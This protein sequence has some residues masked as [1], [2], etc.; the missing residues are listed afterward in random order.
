M[1]CDANFFAVSD[2]ISGVVSVSAC[3][4]DDDDITG[5]GGDVIEP[6]LNVHSGDDVD[7]MHGDVWLK[8][9]WNECWL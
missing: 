2:N 9:R 6:V 1:C 3:S 5:D 7:I 8:E 4:N